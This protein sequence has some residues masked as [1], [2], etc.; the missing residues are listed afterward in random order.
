MAQSFYKKPSYSIYSENVLLREHLVDG[1]PIEIIEI[2]V[3]QSEVEGRLVPQENEHDVVAV[4]QQ[5]FEHLVLDNVRRAAFGAV[6]M[7]VDCFPAPDGA[8]EALVPHEL[9]QRL[10]HRAAT[11]GYVNRFL[12]THISP[13]AIIVRTAVPGSGMVA[14]LNP[15]LKSSNVG[16]AQPRPEDGRDS[17]MVPNEPQP[18]GRAQKEPGENHGRQGQADRPRL[19]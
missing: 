10:G 17:G 15:K 2:A 13:K 6:G 11:K 12:S 3:L 14:T 18:D 1:R 19:A 16:P 9:D 8:I 4:I 5:R 7:L